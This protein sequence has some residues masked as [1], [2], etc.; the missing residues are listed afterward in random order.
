L[1]GVLKHH[2]GSKHIM[3]IVEFKVVVQTATK[4][5]SLHW[6]SGRDKMMGQVP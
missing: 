4:G 5:P 2:F 3:N 6:V 1:F